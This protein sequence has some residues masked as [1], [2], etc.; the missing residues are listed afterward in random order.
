[1]IRC[2][3]RHLAHLD[4]HG[5]QARDPESAAEQPARE[6]RVGEGATAAVTDTRDVGEGAKAVAAGWAA[7]PRFPPGVPCG[8]TRRRIDGNSLSRCL[9]PGEAEAPR[10]SWLLSATCGNDWPGGGSSR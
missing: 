10:R 3:G 1:M 6:E 4:P 8:A 9:G 5:P 2:G 7:A